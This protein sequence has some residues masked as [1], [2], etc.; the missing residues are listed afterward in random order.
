MTTSEVYAH[1]MIHVIE[2]SN[3]LHALSFTYNASPHLL[4]EV[5]S[6][7]CTWVKPPFETAPF[8]LSQRGF[9]ASKENFALW[10]ESRDWKA[11][12]LDGL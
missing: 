5:P 4:D 3:K 12:I 2:S 7:T 11:L 1:A 6:S 10:E 9:H 8:T